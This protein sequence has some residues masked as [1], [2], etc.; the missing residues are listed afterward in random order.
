MRVCRESLLDQISHLKKDIELSST[1]RKHD[2]GRHSQLLDDNEKM[3]QNI[4]ELR[5][6]KVGCVTFW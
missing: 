4:I 3:R 6:S 2:E 5:D 1:E